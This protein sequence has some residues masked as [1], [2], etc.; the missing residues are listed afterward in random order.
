MKNL[1][2][3]E[4]AKHL[5]WH[6]QQQEIESTNTDLIEALI[7][8]YAERTE[9]LK[10]LA[11]QIRFMFEDFTEFD[12][13]AAKKHLKIAS[14]EPLSTL[15][16]L[17][18]T[19]TE[20]SNDSIQKAIDE[21]MTTLDIGMG[22]IGMPLRVAITGSGQSPGMDILCQLLGKDKCLQRLDNAL[23]FIEQRRLASEQR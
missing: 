19:M 5:Q 21:T 16:G 13:K 11:N 8:L 3:A 23:A 10:Q 2:A 17:F 1:S 15:K 7:P 18:E 6:L 4:V 9:T 20:W 14:A 12:A 22:K